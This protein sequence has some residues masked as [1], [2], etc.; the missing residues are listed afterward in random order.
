M[1]GGFEQ[2]RTAVEANDFAAFQTAVVDTPL[3]T[4]ITSQE[5]FDKFVYM[6]TLMEEG[7]TDEAKAIATELGLSE[8]K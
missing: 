6:H 7:K 4:K 2:V 5:Q 3:A 1:K 8:M